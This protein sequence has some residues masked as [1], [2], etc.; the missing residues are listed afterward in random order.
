MSAN[1]LSLQRGLVG[2]WKLTDA[3][4]SGSNAFDST[5]FKNNGNINGTTKSTGLGQSSLSFSTDDFVS[6]PPDKFPTDSISL[7]VWV[8]T[9]FTSKSQAIFGSAN[10]FDASGFTIVVDEPAQ[11][12]T[13][14]AG[15]NGLAVN[16]GGTVLFASNFPLEY[17]KWNHIV[18]QTNSADPSRTSIYLNG[19]QVA[20]TVINAQTIS[21]GPQTATIGAREKNGFGEFSEA[22]IQDAR[23]Y[24]RKLSTDEI[25][26]L[27]NMESTRN[28]SMDIQKDIA[29]NPIF[30]QDS[31]GTDTPTGWVDNSGNWI[32]TDERSFEETFSFGNFF[33]G[34]ASGGSGR[35]ADIFPSTFA[36]QEI[37][38]V[39]P[40]NTYNI[41]VYLNS[42]AGSG[43][44]D[45]TKSQNQFVWEDDG[46]LRVEAL[47]SSSSVIKSEETIWMG[48]T[49][50]L[51]A[52]SWN[53]RE[54][55]FVTPAGTD[56]IRVNIDGGDGNNSVIDKD[57]GHGG[58]AG[59]F[60]DKLSIK[61]I[62]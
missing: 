42:P 59:L 48:Q 60:I 24:N 54:L 2:H 40:S 7:S 20:T 21:L 33:G 55:D 41:S 31:L 62:L 43:N 35:S 10:P 50:N 19:N 23:V 44:G 52:N 53:K 47:D 12:F 16:F 13:Q 9:S 37:T 51:N 30:S 6:I 58:N 27:Y 8:N 57:S 18:A 45:G 39:K 11:G 4:I 28:A 38:D 15:P 61:T 22:R 5:P 56:T 14:N 26:F 49:T 32:V 1:K 3:S 46:R 34:Q 29:E 25:D 17:D 36:Y